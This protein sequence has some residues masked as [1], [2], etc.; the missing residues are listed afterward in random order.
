[1]GPA[2]PNQQNRITADMSDDKNIAALRA[3]L[4]ERVLVLDG[5]TGTYLQDLELTEADFGG[6]ELEGCYENLALTR[7]DAVLAMHEAYLEAGAD[8]IETNTFGGTPLVL[9]EYG[10]EA[11]THEI[12]LRAA[13]LA[14]EAADKHATPQRPRWVAG[15]MGPTTKAITV[16]GGTTFAELEGNFHDQ[17]AGL[18]AGGVDYLLVETSQDTRNVKA[19]LLGI[20]RLFEEAGRRI[21][22]AVS[23]TSETDACARGSGGSARVW[24]PGSRPRGAERPTR[25]TVGRR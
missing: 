16:T 23:G 13:E 12:N 7:P 1:M 11:K 2:K 14:R 3:A 6:P 17:A 20:E 24:L 19:A 22:V 10:L 5:A 8:I 9:A 18:M 25:R 15:S 4:K 21:P